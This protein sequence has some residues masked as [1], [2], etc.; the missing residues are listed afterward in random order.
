MAELLRSYDW[1]GNVRELESVVKRWVVLGSEDR[2][3]AE[4]VARQAAARRKQTSRAGARLG[5]REIGRSAARE[6]ERIA[7]QDAL[8][9]ARG[10]RAAAARALKVSYRTLL[11]KLADTGLVPAPRDKQSS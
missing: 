8:T 1:P 7:L 11:Q 3:R 6:A 9:R 4:L 2:V 5:L 10:N